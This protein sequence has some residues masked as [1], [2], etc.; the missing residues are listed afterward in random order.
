VYAYRLLRDYHEEITREAVHE[1][2]R[3]YYLI[4]THD[5][6]VVDSM[7]YHAVKTEAFSATMWNKNVRF[8]VFMVVKIEVELFWVMTPCSVAVR[9]LVPED[10]AASAFRMKDGGSKL[11]Q[12][13]GIVHHY[14][15]SQC[16]RS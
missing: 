7:G 5:V 13:V 1:L 3:K 4:L 15:A 12:N 9:Y 2:F 10:L 14:I 16:R 8:E 11:L 6:T